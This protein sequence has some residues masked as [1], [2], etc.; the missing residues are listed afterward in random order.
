MRKDQ[1]SINTLQVD[2]KPY[3]DSSSKAGILNNYFSSVFTKDDQSLPPNI[4][5]ESVPNISQIT[6]EVD[7]VYNLL[8][9]LD[10]H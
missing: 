5:S 10:P 7:G 1:V 3:M 2:G 8:T 4:S 6:V 9:N